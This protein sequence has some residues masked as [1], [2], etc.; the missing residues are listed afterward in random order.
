M[1]RRR[2]RVPALDGSAP[3]RSPVVLLIIDAINDFTFD[4]AREVLAGARPMADRIAGSRVAR[5][6]P[7]SRRST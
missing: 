7:G 6:A 1:S 2:G 4:G 3:D 5:G